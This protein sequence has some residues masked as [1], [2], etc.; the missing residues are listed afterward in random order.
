MQY[1]VLQVPEKERQKKKKPNQI[2]RL[3]NR[4]LLTTIT[5]VEL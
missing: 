1:S 4:I 5:L 2:M 3:D